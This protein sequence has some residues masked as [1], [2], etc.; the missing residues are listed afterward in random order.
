MAQHLVPVV[1]APG[2]PGYFEKYRYGTRGT[3]G[4]REFS[5]SDITY[6][7]R[8]SQK[9]IRIPEAPLRLAGQAI[10]ISQLLNQFDH[11]FLSNGGVPAHMVVTPP[12]EDGK[13]RRAFRDQFNRKFGGAGNAG[14][15]AFA[16]T[17]SEPGEFGTTTPQASV[18]VKV[19]GTTQKDSE[20]NT[21]R[22]AKNEEQSIVFGVPLSMLGVSAGSK[23]T[24]M[25]TDRENYW[26]ETIKPYL[27]EFE[28]HINLSLAPKMDGPK[29]I[30][31]FDTS[32]VPE[33]RKAPVFT[34]GGGINAVAAGLISPNDYRLDRGL[35]ADKDPDMDIARPRPLTLRDTF[36]VSSTA[37]GANPDQLPPNPAKPDANPTVVKKD[38]AI[39]PVKAKAVREDLLGIVREQLATELADQRRELQQRLA[40]KRGGKHR[41]HAQLNLG[42][43]Y[44]TEHWAQ[45]LS[46]NLAPS[47]RAAGLLDGEITE[48][49]QDITEA[50]HEHLS[51]TND[52]AG[53]FDT[54]DYMGKL[55]QPGR[56]VSAP[57]DAGYI[58]SAL[59]QISQGQMEA[60][61][62]LKAI[63]G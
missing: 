7:W 43:A 12:F 35:P 32:S 42:L 4:F 30:G 11:A 10:V 27:R 54:D 29:D 55:D 25:Q 18:D 61:D 62:V 44:D 23:Y 24:N 14:K 22:T 60:S 21:L 28:D 2:A 63:A 19:I 31:W 16:E 59:L 1:A 3:Q 50:V 37:P 48:W 39:P 8:P 38:Q 13:Q 45:R 40:G 53:A 56:P 57:V 46:R 5:T 20:I 26:K 34:E 47:L 17:I 51:M 33:L 6:I 41:A 52:M 49:S 15:V 9:D 58:E 36:T